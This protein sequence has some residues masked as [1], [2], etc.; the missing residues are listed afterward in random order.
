MS[1]PGARGEIWSYG[2]RNPWRF[3][4]DRAT[5]DMWTGDV[6]DAR[7]EEVDLQ[8]A[9]SQAGENYGWPLLE[10]TDCMDESRCHDPGFVAPLVTYGHD[11]NC[12][13]VGGYT[14]RG[15]SVPGLAGQYLFGDLCTGGV[16]TLVGGNDTG[17]TRVELGFQPIKISSFGEDPSGEGYVVDLQGGAVYRI[18]DG[19]LPAGR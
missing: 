3:S 7:S 13:V 16:F 2:F 14:Y 11:M 18:V 12:A 4:F 1:Q 15:Q 10:G 9:R 8:P 17:W 5:G 6:G 19:A